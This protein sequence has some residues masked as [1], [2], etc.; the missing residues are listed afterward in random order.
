M[1]ATSKKKTVS[2]R[3]KSDIASSKR[4]AVIST[5]R[6]YRQHTNELTRSADPFDVID[7]APTPTSNYKKHIPGS[8]GPKGT[9]YEQRVVAFVDILGFKEIIARSATDEALVRRIYGALDL[10][11]DNFAEVFAAEVG[12]NRTSADFDD[13]F[14]TFSDCIVISVRPQIEE[15][16]L[17]VFMVFRV[18][19]QLLGNGF[20][21]RGGVA[22]GSLYHRVDKQFDTIGSSIV[23]SSGP[24][25]VPMVF[26][27]A[28][29]DAYNFESAHADGP[30]VILQQGV[31]KDI[32]SY[33]SKNSDKLAHFLRAH[34]KRAADGPAY[35][36]IFADLENDGNF[37][38][39]RRDLDAELK[40]IHKNI[41]DELDRA[42]DKPHHFKKNAQLAR[43]FNDA[44]LASARKQHVI[45]SSKLPTGHKDQASPVVHQPDA[46][47]E[48]SSSI[49]STANAVR[50]AR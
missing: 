37:Y 1:A 30:R 17:L 18:C 24:L 20:F 25:P 48:L 42:A 41:C 31:W 10:R 38:N 44:L 7:Q 23:Q 12:L 13:L 47:H 16:G 22:K 50:L 45:P 33:C 39:E 29:V 28:F 11:H 14:H 4:R 36:D 2:R 43:Q 32:D 8:D 9:M 49:G 19:R 26:G 6:R 40:A 46:A 15:V 34:V 27:P 3:K 5:T 21:S 35:I